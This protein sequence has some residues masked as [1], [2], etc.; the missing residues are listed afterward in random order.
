VSE[1][2]MLLLDNGLQAYL[3]RAGNEDVTRIDIS[4]QAGA[5][6]QNKKLIANSTGK[7]LLEGTTNLS[8]AF[9]AE[10]LDFFGAYLEVNINAD[11]AVLSLYSL[12][13][14]LNEMLP[15]LGELLSM[16]AFPEQELLIHLERKKQEFLVNNEKVKYVAM[17][18]FVKMVFGETSAYGQILNENDFELVKRND[19]LDFFTKYYIPERAYMVVSG[20]I[21]DDVISLVNKHIGSGWNKNHFFEEN[22][23]FTVPVTEKE[24]Y[25][26]RPGSLQSAIRIGRPIINKTHPDYDRFILLNTIFGGYFG[27]R[28][29]SN[30][31]E[32]KG[33]TYGV[34]SY[35]LNYTYGSFFSVST[36]VNSKHTE[37]AVFE[38]IKEMEL[39]RNE[40]V[41]EK[42]LDLVKNYIYGTFLRNFDGPFALADRFK[43]VK[44]FGLG[45]DYYKKSLD[46]IMQ[47]DAIQLIETAQTYLNPEDMIQLVVGSYGS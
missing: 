18:E 40:K 45:F 46:S 23:L 42:E 21:D 41:G 27:S 24:K 26:E 29:M 6:F 20:K 44:D 12:T 43:A 36:E 25:I 39:L 10:K 30:L 17:N 32:D 7:L 3:I 22:I 19:L 35:I 33:F 28:L 15:L 11:N 2:E 37:K 1:P 47:V 4:V 5:A 34:S 31:R 9:I 16:P 13:K 38:I 8:S 14:H